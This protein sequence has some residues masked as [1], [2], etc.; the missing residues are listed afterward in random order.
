MARRHTA[1][2]RA[3]LLALTALPFALEG[4]STDRTVSSSRTARITVDLDPWL[5]PLARAQAQP[6]PSQSAQWRTARANLRLIDD[7]LESYRKG[8]V[9]LG[10]DERSDIRRAF[11]DVI[12]G[13]RFTTYRINAPQ[14]RAIVYLGLGPLP[15]HGRRDRRCDYEPAAVNPVPVQTGEPARPSWCDAAIDTLSRDAAWIHSTILELGRSGGARRAKAEE[16]DALKSMAERARQIVITTPRCGC[17]PGE[18]ADALLASTREAVDSFAGSSMPA[19]MTLRGEQVQRI[20]KLADSVE[21]SL[22]HCL[23]GR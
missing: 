2:L 10:D 19:W 9:D 16:L 1:A 22:I 11:G 18:D 20:A 23:S 12:P 17:T 6:T 3:A 4:Q 14:A 8:Y 5:G 21:R 13:Q 15:Q 7:A